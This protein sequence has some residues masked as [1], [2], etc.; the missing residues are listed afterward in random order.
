MGSS[1]LFALIDALDFSTSPFLDTFF[2]F[3]ALVIRGLLQLQALQH[4][5][6][7]LFVCFYSLQPHF[8]AKKTVYTVYT[9]L[10][11]SLTYGL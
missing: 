2:D 10:Q 8:N 5:L 1:T 11:A 4:R 6:L 7:L 3:L 9:V